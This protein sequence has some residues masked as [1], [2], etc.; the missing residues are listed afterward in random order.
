VTIIAASIPFF[1]V[2]IKQVSS[3]GQSVSRK[4]SYRL[5]SYTGSRGLGESRHP[6]A[7]QGAPASGDNRSDISILGD[8]AWPVGGR[9]VKES[10]VTVEYS[11][12]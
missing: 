5:G 8:D 9:I 4:Q 10:V 7:R 12:T 11:K 3:R 2:L 6:T 1:R